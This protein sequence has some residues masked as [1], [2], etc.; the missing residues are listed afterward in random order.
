MAQ[1]NITLNENEILLLMQSDRE[2][3]FAKLLQESLNGILKA[4]SAAQLQAEPYERSDA[5]RDYRNG[6]RERDL[7]TRIGTITLTVPKHRSEP[8]KTMIFD[9]YQ[10]SEAALIASM[11]EMVVNGV[12][13]RKVANVVETLCG[14]SISKSAVSELCKDLDASVNAFRSRPLTEH[15][16]FV[17]IDATY[18]KVRENSKIIS[19]AFMIAYGTGSQGHREVLGFGAY[20]NESKETWTDFLKSLKERNLKDVRMFISDAHEGIRHAISHVFPDTPWQRCQFHFIHNILDKA[21]KKYVAGLKTELREMFDSKTLLA[22]RAKRDS[23]INDYRD[24]AESAMNCLDEGFDDSMT[25]MIFPE[26]IRKKARTSNHLE[27]LNRELKRRSSVIGIFPC[28]AS[29]N[30]LMGAVLMEYHDKMQNTRRK[31]IFMPDYNE[32][33]ANSDR[34][35]ARAE[36]QRLLLTA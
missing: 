28:T 7:T 3:A 33:E 22:A 35:K 12:S 15:Y 26:K 32:I 30:R 34:L 25:V 1:L 14:A 21:P 9:N 31:V 6:S 13:T 10:R 4:E 24:V 16:P 8:F 18:F 17:T 2:G 19:K 27:R 5:R 23:I 11:A 20:P 36:E 29:L